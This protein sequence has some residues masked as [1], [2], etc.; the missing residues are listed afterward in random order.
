MSGRWVAVCRAALPHPGLRCQRAP[1]GWPLRRPPDQLLLVP[2]VPA[3]QL[4]LG[5]RLADKELH[6]PS[7]KV[8][9]AVESLRDQLKDAEAETPPTAAPPPPP[10]SPSPPSPPAAPAPAPERIPSPVV[11]EKTP[12]PALVKEPTKEAV[13]KEPPRRSLW[14]RF[15]DEVKHYYHGFKLLFININISRKLIWRV[16]NG[17]SLSRR[18]NRQVSVEL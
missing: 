3:R 7:S 4:Q 12:E 14:I 2:T 10:A 6:R 11:S 15:L 16:L 17:A 18:E 13:V 5:R 8:E 1:G 9:E